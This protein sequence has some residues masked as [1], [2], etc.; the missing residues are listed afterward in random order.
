MRQRLDRLIIAT[1]FDCADLGDM[2]LS[3]GAFPPH[4]VNWHARAGRA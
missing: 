2:P 1:P 4:A 3:F